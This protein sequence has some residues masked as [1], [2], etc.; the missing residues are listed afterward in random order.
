MAYRNLDGKRVVITGA[1]S[2][3]GEQLTRVLASRGCRIV[4]NA[5]R[6]D[7]LERLR[8][9]LAEAGATIEVVHGDITDPATRTRLLEKVVAAFG[10][11]DILVNNA[12]IGAIG[13]F[14]E[15]DSARLER[16]MR[17]NF[18]APA[19]LTRAALTLLMRG[20]AKQPLIVN[21]S[22]VLGHRAVPLKSEY[23]TSKFALHGWSDA[24]RAE[25]AEQ[26]VD[27]LLVSP[28]TTDSEFFDSVIENTTDRDWKLSN[29]KS[30][31]YVARRTARAMEKGSHEIIL[32]WSGWFLVIFDR[33][34]PTVANKMVARFGKAGGTS[35]KSKPSK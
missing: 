35:V 26:G 20:D 10:G 5:R 4:I 19:E 18:F 15:A 31:A 32:S 28:S 24:L 27:V 1:S 16:V 2:G 17:V 14:C 3:I 8:D 25:L 11:L 34:L 29:A 23:C 13:P 22:S 21:I 12:G 33:L 30:P 9:E 7:R 6:L